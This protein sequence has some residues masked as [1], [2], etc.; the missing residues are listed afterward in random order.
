M[1]GMPTIDS[2]TPESFSVIREQSSYNT[3]VHTPVYHYSRESHT[4]HDFYSRA[5][6]IIFPS[7]QPGAVRNHLRW[8]Q[9]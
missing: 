4:E 5:H 1:A 6:R 2:C 3:A 9:R 7:L 8:V